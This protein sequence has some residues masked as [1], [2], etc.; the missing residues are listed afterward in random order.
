MVIEGTLEKH[1]YL[2]TEDGGWS[3]WTIQDDSKCAE[4]SKS[5]LWG[6]P[7]YHLCNNPQRKYDGKPCSADYSF[8][9]TVQEICTGNNQSSPTQFEFIF[10]PNL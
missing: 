3:P 4:L 7:K 9:E 10:Y 6:K 5:N 2:S 8:S 1:I